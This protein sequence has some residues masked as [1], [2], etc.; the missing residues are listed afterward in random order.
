MTQS[1]VDNIV[2]R[3]VDL[4]NGGASG[5]SGA[6]GQS[7]ASRL[8]SLD[9]ACNVAMQRDDTEAALHFAASAALG[10]ITSAITAARVAFD[11]R[12]GNLKNELRKLVPIVREAVENEIMIHQDAPQTLGKDARHWARLSAQVQ[13][14]RQQAAALETVPGWDD[15][16][17]AEY[18]AAT[19][20]QVKALDDLAKFMREVGDSCPHG[21]Q[22]NTAGFVEVEQHLMG[23]ASS[24]LG[25]GSGGGMFYRRTAGAISM[26]QALVPRVAPGAGHPRDGSLAGDG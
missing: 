3:V 23:A 7:L 13:G 19:R 12:A 11:G 26:L 25:A 20:V 24:V 1:L 9:S 17:A 16:G 8:D 18:A 5:S 22:M 4:M 14:V 21:A 15:D 6:P 2:E 10:P